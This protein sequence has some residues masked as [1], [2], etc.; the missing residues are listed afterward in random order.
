MNIPTMKLG[1]ILK[2]GSKEF[3]LD[4]EEVLIGRNQTCDLVLDVR[5]SGQQRL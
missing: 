3:V 5:L 4:K 1:F 2:C